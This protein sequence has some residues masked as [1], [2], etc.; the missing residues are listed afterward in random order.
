MRCPSAGADAAS[1]AAIRAQRVAIARVVLERALRRHEITVGAELL[2]LAF[3]ER[4]AAALEGD[5]WPEFFAWVDR[6]CDKHAGAA[7]I[8]RILTLATETVAASLASSKRERVRLGS[9]FGSIAAEVRR[10]AGRPR[11]DRAAAVNDALDEVD[12]ALDRLISQLNRFDAATAD[13]SR[14]VSM[15]C[16]RIAKKMALT[17]AETT[18]VMR[19]GLIHDIGKVTTPP[20]IL[21]SPYRLVEDDL[22]TMRQHAAAGAA[23]VGG[24]PIVAHLTPAARSHHERIDGHGYP[25]GHI[26]SDIP[27]AV[28]IVSVA[29]SFNAMIGIRPYRP[30]MPP[31][32]ALEQLRAHRDTQFDSTVVA[33]MIEVVEPQR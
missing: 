4:F 24:I 9:Q 23:I 22:E 13:H 20:E 10:I 3:V 11:L 33:A 26:G 6:T 29:D 1:A 5:R 21:N 32:Q 16:A 12:V 28:R 30:P 25:D 18:F 31:T 8:A 15:W 2:A 7:P 27:L 19:A 14:A 17:P